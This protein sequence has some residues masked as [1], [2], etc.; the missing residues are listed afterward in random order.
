MKSRSNENLLQNEFHKIHE[1][2]LLSPTNAN[3]PRID[4][5]ASL[6]E[7]ITPF[8]LYILLDFWGAVISG[9]QRTSA[10]VNHS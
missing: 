7:R 6:G 9:G 1:R 3:A 5:G 4:W 2:G 10:S 8:N